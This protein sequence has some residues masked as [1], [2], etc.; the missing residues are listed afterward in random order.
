MNYSSAD[1][2]KV[3][4]GI[5]G[6]HLILALV[7]VI[8]GSFFWSWA[9]D[10]SRVK[11]FLSGLEFLKIRT[12]EVENEWPLDAH[13][14][15]SW[16][17]PLQNE[18]LLLV[19]SKDIA[20][21]LQS[22]PWVDS[23]SVKKGYPNRLFI[24]LSSKKPQALIVQKGQPWFIDP[25]GHLIERATPVLLKGLELPFLSVETSQTK[26]DVKEMLSEYEKMKKL[27]QGKFSV[28]QIVLGKF[29]YF[30]TYFSKPKIEV[31]WSYENWET[32]LKNLMALIDSPPSQI[33]QL[34]RI[35]LVFPKKAIVSS[36]ISH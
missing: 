8:S 15:K 5:R 22:H 2:I 26:W 18:N 12:I 29:P 11:K 30:K 9:S 7:A 13:Q 1:T 33:G 10:Q 20:R 17:S 4:S 21:S 27:S 25:K 28:S 35:N 19:D 23:V 16:I 24:N 32:Q 34:R 3:G 36:T 31:W 14:V 6:V